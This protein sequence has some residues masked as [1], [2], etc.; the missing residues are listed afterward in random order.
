MMLW[1]TRIF[2]AL[3]PIAAGTIAGDS[4]T[5]WSTAPRVVATVLVWLA[6]FVVLVALFVPRAIGLTVVRVVVPPLFV[7]ALV[8]TANPVSGTA[9]IVIGSAWTAFAVALALGRP[10]AEAAIDANSW[11][12]ERRYPLRIPPLLLATL[13]P[14]AVAVIAGTIVAVPLLAATK[15]WV[16]AVIVLVVGAPLSYAMSRSLHSL[17]R[18]FLVLV[19]A[20]L[21]VSDPI[22]LADPVLFPRDHI[23]AL[24]RVDPRVAAAT[25]THDA[26]TGSVI[27]TMRLTFTEDATILR[28]IPRRESELV[29]VRHL[30][31]SPARPQA[32]LNMARERRIKGKAPA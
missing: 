28:A 18:R 13:V 6:W 12:T 5:H 15:H 8:A 4:V 31:F 22:T 3:T 23:V 10:F 9:T 14:F 27:V 7:A 17:T 24:D 2:W 25:D 11:G 19:P 29:E 26:R 21:V 20:G 1:I 16:F 32:F 30:L